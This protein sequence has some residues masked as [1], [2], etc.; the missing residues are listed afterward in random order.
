MKIATKSRSER[1]RLSDLNDPLKVWEG[2]R[3]RSGMFTI[4]SNWLTIY[5]KR[6]DNRPIVLKRKI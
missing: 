6:P 3:M 2:R 4:S 1:L 5:L